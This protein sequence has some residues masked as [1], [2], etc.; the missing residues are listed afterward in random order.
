MTIYNRRTVMKIDMT[1]DGAWGSC[2]KG[3]ISGFMALRNRYDTVVC[4]YGTQAG[5][6]Y[7][8]E[9]RGIH[10]MVQQLPVG[11]IS[12]SVKSVML[13]PGALI[14]ADTL[15][16]EID[17]YG[18]Y[19]IGKNIYIHEHAAVVTDE[20]SK[21]EHERGQTKM[22]STAKGVGQ[23]MVDRILRDP[24]SKAVAKYGFKG[25][26]LEKYVV[27]RF[28]YD[29]ILATAS[30]VLIEGA[31]G[32]GLSL[33]HGEWP[34]CTSRD[35][36]PW[37]IAADC[38]IPFAWAPQIKVTNAMRTYPIRVNNRDG[39]SGPA[40]PGQRELTWDEIRKPPELTTVTK[41]PRRIFE[42]SPAQL[43]HAAFHCHDA[44]SDLA[45]TFADYCKTVEDLFDLI[46]MFKRY[47]R[48]RYVVFGPDDADVIDIGSEPMGSAYHRIIHKFA[49][50]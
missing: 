5:H 17:K 49:G 39:S 10:M 24:D 23:A 48:V 19:L 4:S 36:T 33:Y 41:L 38:G 29:T 15:I 7:N 40:Y 21:R 28:E 35:V 13:G 37:Q 44:G 20:H 8:N 2:G 18:N 46:S 6:T 50:L 27:D 34:Y 14:H 30:H 42:F 32:F 31:Q 22:G 26:P 25:T 47:G 9:A 12:P 3:G 43:R 11:I 45:I 1:M 16:N